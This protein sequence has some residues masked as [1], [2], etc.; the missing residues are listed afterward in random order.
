MQ[1]ILNFI[2]FSVLVTMVGCSSSV[3]KGAKYSWVSGELKAK[4]NYPI[5]SV[6]AASVEALEELE[7]NMVSKDQDKLV[8]MISVR[9]A[10]GEEIEVDINAL[11][12]YSSMLKIK[13]R[14]FGG[15]DQAKIIYKDIK[16]RLS[17]L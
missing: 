5:Q 7:L 14:S 10:G 17:A 8:A 9:N 4:L 11:S 2:F 16:E 15:E 13:V 1:K 12:D 3:D 6:Y